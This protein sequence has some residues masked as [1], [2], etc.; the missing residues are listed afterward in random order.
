[1]HFQTA[2]HEI[3][4][5]LVADEGHRNTLTTTGDLGTMWINKLREIFVQHFAKAGA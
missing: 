5:S 2:Y 4:T 1:M 3:L